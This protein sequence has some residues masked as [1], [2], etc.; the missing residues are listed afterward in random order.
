MKLKKA[1]FE[2]REL[3][4]YQ[5]ELFFEQWSE[6]FWAANWMNVSEINITSFKKF[7]LADAND[8]LDDSE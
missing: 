5:V 6:T 1:V 3:S 8:P 7:L 2:L 4:D